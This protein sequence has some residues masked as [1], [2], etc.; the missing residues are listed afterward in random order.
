[1]R[2]RRELP[3]YLNEAHGSE[4]GLVRQLQAQIAMTPKG[5]LQGDE[6]WPGYDELGVDEV[7]AVLSEGD[8]AE[9]RRP[10]ATSASTKPRRRPPGHRARTVQ[11][12]TA[13]PQADA[14]K[15]LLVFCCA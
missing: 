4:L 6:P 14:K 12:L 5:S 10:A 9:S 1:M 8:E 15:S 3:V 7:R 11:R 2:C 13:E